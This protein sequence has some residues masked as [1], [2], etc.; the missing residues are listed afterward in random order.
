[1][2]VVY[3]NRTEAWRD[4]QP[5]ATIHV[6][7]RS[8]A[9]TLTTA[10]FPMEDLTK[11]S[12]WLE[13]NEIVQEGTPVV[14]HRPS[15][16][17]KIGSEKGRRLAR[18]AEM[19]GNVAIV[20]AVPFCETIEN[21]Y[22][23]WRYIDR[24][25]LGYQHFYAFS[26]GHT[27]VFEGRVVRSLDHRLNA[28]KVRPHCQ[29]EK[30]PVRSHRSTIVVPCTDDEHRQYADNR[31]QLFA[32]KKTPQPIITALGDLVHAFS[33]RKTKAVE[34]ATQFARPM[35]IVN[36]ASYAAWYREQGIPA[37]TYAKPADVTKCDGLVF[38]EPPI[39][40]PYRRLFIEAD[41]SESCEVIDVR[42][43]TKADLFLGGRTDEETTSVFRFC[44]LLNESLPDTKCS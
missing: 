26:G 44:E 11:T 9:K 34:L 25:I 4:V 22:T 32:T 16:H 2:R 15:I 6:A 14:F 41:A 42:C 36:V 27:E 38:A 20:D 37:M 21:L 31:E 18:L 3:T 24:Q 28:S 43:D 23:T 19:S 10:S 5:C 17:Y 1:M 39:V 8:I 13:L 7:P 33:G 35:V 30:Q 40:Y 29:L 12:T